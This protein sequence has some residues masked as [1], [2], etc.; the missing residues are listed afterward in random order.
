MD[1]YLAAGLGAVGGLL[2][3]LVSLFGLLSA[4]REERRA[5]K[6]GRKRSLPP[7]GTYLDLRADIPVALAR[8]A[9]GAIAGLVFAA[10]IQGVI[11]AIVIG[12][13][14]PALLR[15]FGSARSL[16]QAQQQADKLDPTGQP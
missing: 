10:Q 16:A 2:V 8:M 14:A 12:S 9:L 7:F 3:E 1:L 6:R 5:L 4:W 13:A 11:A 15:Q